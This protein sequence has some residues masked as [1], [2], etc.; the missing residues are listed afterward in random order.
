MKRDRTVHVITVFVL[1]AGLIGGTSIIGTSVVGCA[2]VSR[3]A[4]ISSGITHTTAR[5]AL[6]GWDEY[7]SQQY[8]TV[9]NLT[10]AN[11]EKAE[12]LRAELLEKE[13][14]VR[15]AYEKYQAAQLAVLTAAQ[16]FSQ[17]A[18]SD[19][20]SPR[21]EDQLTASIAAAGITLSALVDLIQ[22]FGVK[23]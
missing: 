10:E 18:P 6:T 4:Y 3:N 9:T 22:K 16:A 2:S 12:K 14:K 5:V 23:L 7:L 1:I 20:N 8:T 15:D 19:P 21:A 17:I 11:P 13:V